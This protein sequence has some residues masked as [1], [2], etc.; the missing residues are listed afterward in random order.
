MDRL[1]CKSLVVDSRT[2]LVLRFCK[3]EDKSFVYELMRHYL[4]TPFNQLTP[5]GWS[6]AKFKQGFNSSRITIIEHDDMSVGFFDIEF[7][8]TEAYVHNLHLSGDYQ[9]EY[10][11]IR[12]LNFIEKSALERGMV[13][14]KM[15]VFK[16]KNQHLNILTNKLGYHIF[17][18]VPEEHSF[19][20]KK[21]L[22][23]RD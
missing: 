14:I 3:E 23:R 19:F 4:E 11:G 15:K 12:I 16:D 20:I 1:E 22:E 9:R 8:D 2:D 21:Y 10:N 18:D 6:R 17:Q 7:Q 13:S 5:E